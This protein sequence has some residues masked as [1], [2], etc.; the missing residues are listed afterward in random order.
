MDGF[1]YKKK[2][3]VDCEEIRIA[4][5]LWLLDDNKFIPTFAMISNIMWE[6]R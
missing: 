4:Q 3:F 5:D 1:K 2:S 6:Q